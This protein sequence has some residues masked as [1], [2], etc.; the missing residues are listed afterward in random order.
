MVLGGHPNFFEEVLR[1]FASQKKEKH[2]HWSKH[3]ILAYQG[4]ANKRKLW[5]APQLISAS[6]KNNLP[7]KHNSHFTLITLAL[8]TWV[9]QGTKVTK[10]LMFSPF[11]LFLFLV[12]HESQ[13]STI[14]S[15]QS[16]FTI[17]SEE[18][19]EAKKLNDSKGRRYDETLANSIKQSTRQKGK[20]RNKERG[21]ESKPEEKKPRWVINGQRNK[22]C[23]KITHEEV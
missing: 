7:H 17:M 5:R 11:L 9:S 21:P 19:L 12:E 14:F 16:F 23:S 22:S 6:H 2:K 3:N 8:I 10:F 1:F 4:K 13:Y 20:R 18:N 15:M